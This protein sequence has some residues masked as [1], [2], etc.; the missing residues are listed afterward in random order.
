M[1]K[2][3]LHFG[4][5]AHLSRSKEQLVVQLKDEQ[6]T[7]KTMPI[8]DIGMIV[9]EHGE[10]TL[11]N[12]LL[13]SLVDHQIALITC[14]EKYMPVGQFLPYSGH[15]VQTERMRTQ[16]SASV[17]LKK[18]LWQQTVK[19]KIHNQAKLLEEIHQDGKR[20]HALK[21]KVKS[22]DPQNIEGQAAAFYWSSI[23]GN[24]FTR[25]REMSSPNAQLNYGYAILR[26]IV[27]RALTASGMLPS[28]GIFHRNK[29]N[30]FC[31]A[32]DIMEPYRPYV[33][34]IVLNMDL[35]AP[36]DQ[37]LTRE[38]KIELL[39]L[40]QVDVEINEM[41][42]PLGHAVSITTSSLFRCFDGEQRKISYPEY[43]FE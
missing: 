35:T 32:D 6:K 28:F 21:E 29:Y 41:K 14:N 17:T 27:A 16:I 4:N 10:I 43:H 3:T 19:A 40:A 5:P 34:R 22:G 2:R 31:L 30:A 39:K 38:Q 7:T 11:S 26:S 23:Y 12:A 42:R 15:N 9:L 37:G 13:Q 36:E 18:Q 24:T 25:A 20:L 1:L 33:D 8:E